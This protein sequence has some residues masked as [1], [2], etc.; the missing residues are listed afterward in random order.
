MSFF[1]FDKIQRKQNQKRDNHGCTEAPF[2]AVDKIVE[3]AGR[4]V[5]SCHHRDRVS[6][7]AVRSAEQK[8]LNIIPHSMDT[9]CDPEIAFQF[10]QKVEPYT[11]QKYIQTE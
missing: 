3:E 10:D 2:K 8:D 1:A 11:K 5:R 4:S 9:A 6:R 7:S